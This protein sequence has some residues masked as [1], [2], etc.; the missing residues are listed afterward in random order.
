M[1]YLC[2][3]IDGK[4]RYRNIIFNRWF[5]ELGDG[6]E[7]HKSKIETNKLDFYSSLLVK[8]NNPIK[9]SLIQAFH[10]TIDFWFPEE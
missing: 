1:L 4:A 2:L 7:Q 5:R 8:S 9:N 10:F 6:F 3:N